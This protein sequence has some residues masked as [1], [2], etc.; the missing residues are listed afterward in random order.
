MKHQI[1]NRI[2]PAC[3]AICMMLALFACS[4]NSDPEEDDDGGAVSGKRIKSY[5][6]NTASGVNGPV[7]WEF[8]Y[9][10]DG[11]AKQIDIYDKSSKRVIYSTFT[12]NSDGTISVAEQIDNTYS[13]TKWVFDHSYNSDK[14]LKKIQGTAYLIGKVDPVGANSTDFSYKD[15]KISR[16]VL[17][18]GL[19]TVQTDY[20]YDSKGRI[21]AS[22][23]KQGNGSS[24][25]N[26]FS[27]NSDGTLQ[28]VNYQDGQDIISINYTW[29]N[30]KTTAG[31]VFHVFY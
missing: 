31:A 20:E 15:G 29:E 2:I 24:F 26:T 22:I 23:Q 19:I 13:N 6:V 5:V 7:R 18:N 28:K 1:K 14:T 17:Q 16:V 12:N 21:S 9:K 4:D 3:T 25:K 30:G 10:S 8:S 11:S 27:Y